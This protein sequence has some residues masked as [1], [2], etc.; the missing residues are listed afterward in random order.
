MIDRSKYYS[1]SQVAQLRAACSHSHRRA[2]VLQ[3]M[4]VEAAL[5][6]GL[7]ANELARLDLGNFDLPER[8]VRVYRS[9]K[10]NPTW[11]TLPVTERLREA[12]LEYLTKRVEWGQE[13]HSGAPLF[14]GQR[15]RLSVRG[16]QQAWTKAVQRA[17][18]PHV[19]IHGARH[20][21]AVSL[22]QATGDIAI[23]KEWLG[24]SN[25][26]TTIQSYGNVSFDEMAQAAAKASL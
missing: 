13:T 5:E 7:R 10:G 24:H 16:L 12:L 2:D 17:G 22:R 21:R 1:P 8:T 20:T 19:G 14:L 23:V 3:T 4:V 15:G 26:Q 9:K 25:V 11:S 6:L 18:L